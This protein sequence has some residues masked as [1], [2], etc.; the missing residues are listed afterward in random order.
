[1][2]RYEKSF[3]LHRAH[4]ED[5]INLLSSRIN[6]LTLVVSDTTQGS[7][8]I[9]NLILSIPETGLHFI[10]TMLS[11]PK[12]LLR[13]VLRLLLGVKEKPVDKTSTSSNKAK[14]KAVRSPG[15]KRVAASGR[16]D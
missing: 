2:R 11:L 16:T 14:G 8:G 9:L 5:R 15:K 4:T 10:Q 12:A 6:D 1:V 13:R 7:A 3:A